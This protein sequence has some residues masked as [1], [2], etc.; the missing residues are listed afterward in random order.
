VRLALEAGHF[1]INTG[2]IIV[3]ISISIAVVVCCMVVVMANLFF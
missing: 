1:K 2:G 3:V